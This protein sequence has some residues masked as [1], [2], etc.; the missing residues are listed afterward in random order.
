MRVIRILLVVVFSLL[1]IYSY[2]QGFSIIKSYNT[3]DYSGGNR[4]YSVC[5]DSRGL[6]FAGDKNGILVFDGEN[7]TRFDCGFAITS[8]TFDNEGVL[9]YAGREGIGSLVRDSLNNFKINSLNHLVSSNTVNQKL[10]NAKVFNIDGQIVFAL[11]NVLLINTPERLRIIESPYL[12]EYYQELNDQLYLY[13]RKSGIFKLDGQK[14]KLISDTED[15][16]FLDIRGFLGN[17][18]Q[19]TI[20]CNGNGILTLSNGVLNVKEHS[21]LSALLSENGVSNTTQLSGNDYCIS[22]YYEGAIFVDNGLTITRYFDY[23]VGL[24][25]NFV[26]SVHRDKWDNLW[27]GTANGISVARLAFPFSVINT[28]EGIGTGYKSVLYNNRLY[29]ATSQGLYVQSFYN[30]TDKPITKLFSGHVWGL[31]VVEGKLYFGHGSGLYV[32]NENNYRKVIPIPCGWEIKPFPGITSKYLTNTPFGFI[33]INFKNGQIADFHEVTGIRENTSNFEIIGDKEVWAKGGNTI[34]NFTFNESYNGVVNLKQ[35]DSV[36]AG[37]ALLNIGKIDNKLYFLAEKGIYQFDNGEKTFVRDSLLVKLGTPNYLQQDKNGV[38]WAFENEKLK[39]YQMKAGAYGLTVPPFFS[40]IDGSFPVNYE[41]ICLLDS[42]FLL[43]GN[44]NGF[45]CLDQSQKLK[46]AYSGVFFH[47]ITARNRKGEEK[48]IW[49]EFGKDYEQYKMTIAEK[50]SY[51]YNSVKFVFSSGSSNYAE[52]KYQ[53]KLVGYDDWSQWS[54]ENTK[55]YTNLP[56]G[57]YQFIVRAMNK[58]EEFSYVASCVFVVNPPWYSTDWAF[59]LYFILFLCSIWAANKI[60]KTHAEKLI[61][62]KEDERYK[63]NQK[64][65]SENLKKEKENIEQKNEQLKNEVVYKSKDLAN[66]TMSLIKKNQFLIEL[67]DELDKMKAFSEQNKLVT[68]DIRRVI[69]KINNGIDDE[70]SWQV[71]EDYFDHVHENF[72]KKMKKRY[73]S[74]T[75]K[76]LRMCAYIRMNLSSKEIAPLL[77]ITVRGVEISRYRL[78]KK[79]ELERDENLSDFLFRF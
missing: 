6:L 5:S 41:N 29:L 23:N 71:F 42:N 70:E 77:D 49:G 17:E 62:R 79:M 73:P 15:V 9:F 39:P 8:L 19:L 46:G 66:S 58:S 47:K 3:E 10:R 53:V 74:L 38:I 56:S 20:L 76:D 28:R 40:Y 50:L 24:S 65:I 72:M 13:S 18:L 45:W 63:A 2:G 33:V 75:S 78:R 57:K 37:N 43:I 22:T 55:E 36:E 26:F 12:F 54:S 35:Y 1:A 52:I 34:Y 60:Y 59:V 30:R 27:M 31:S 51:T 48:Q 67:R 11:D 21:K 44:E 7:W 61:K 16:K 69:R 64:K 4:I 25:N 32:L 68:E 14:L